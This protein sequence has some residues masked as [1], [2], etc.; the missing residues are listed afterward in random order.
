MVRFLYVCIP[1]ISRTSGLSDNTV[2]AFV[3][4]HGFH[5]GE[6]G[7]FGKRTHFRLSARVPMMV[8]MP[9]MEDYGQPGKKKT[10]SP[11]SLNYVYAFAI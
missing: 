11:I 7:H 1:A 6:H 8:R 3:S 9:S 4:D 10:T 2:V 5:L